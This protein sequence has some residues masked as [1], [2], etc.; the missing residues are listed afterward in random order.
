MAKA[1]QNVSPA[2]PLPAFVEGDRYFVNDTTYHIVLSRVNYLWVKV[3][4]FRRSQWQKVSLADLLPLF[5]E[6]GR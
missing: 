5:V 4:I 6:G 3:S 2:D 1:Y